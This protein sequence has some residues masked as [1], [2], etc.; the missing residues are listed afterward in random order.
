MPEQ[1]INEV[2]AKRLSGWIFEMKDQNKVREEKIKALKA[3]NLQLVDAVEEFQ[4]N[5]RQM[6]ELKGEVRD[7]IKLLNTLVQFAEKSSGKEF[8]DDGP[9]YRNG[10][11]LEQ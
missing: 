7:N 1:T 4:D 2:E 5:S 9:L 3:R 8:V 11:E 10:G 6:D